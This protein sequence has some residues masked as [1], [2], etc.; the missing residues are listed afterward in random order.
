[1]QLIAILWVLCCAVLW[2]EHDM[3]QRSRQLLSVACVVVVAA[4]GVQPYVPQGLHAHVVHLTT[5]AHGHSS[6]AVPV[7]RRSWTIAR[8]CGHWWMVITEPGRALHL[9][10]GGRWC[11]STQPAGQARSLAVALS[12]CGVCTRVTTGCWLGL[13]GGGVASR[14][15]E[16]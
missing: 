16:L 14:D 7:S 10:P 1:M 2:F 8:P 3:R 5:L 13:W 12:L 15:V 11:K 4:A 6:F 9:F